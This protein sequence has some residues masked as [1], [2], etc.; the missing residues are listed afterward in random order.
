MPEFIVNPYTAQHGLAVQKVN[1]N[2]VTAGNS[3][4]SGDDKDPMR[5]LILAKLI[6]AGVPTVNVSDDRLLEE[7]V[8][9]V[10]A[11]LLRQLDQVNTRLE[12]LG[13][14]AV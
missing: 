2:D 8:K 10:R 9:V 11:P 6:S 4:P 1:A 5:R 13:H 14:R 12:L 7:Y 3:I